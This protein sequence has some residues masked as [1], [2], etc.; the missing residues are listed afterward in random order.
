MYL[1]LFLIGIFYGCDIIGRLLSIDAYL[2]FMA[3]P[4]PSLTAEQLKHLK[5]LIKLRISDPLPTKPQN[6]EYEEH[7]FVVKFQ[8]QEKKRSHQERLSGLGYLL[9]IRQ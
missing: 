3:A 5:S 6:I 8:R 1:T 9:I 2:T 7:R 4:F